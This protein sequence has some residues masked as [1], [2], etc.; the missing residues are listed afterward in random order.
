MRHDFITGAFVDGPAFSK[1]TKV[2]FMI[3]RQVVGGQYNGNN[4]L[5]LRVINDNDVQRAWGS[6]Y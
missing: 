5:L 6:T 1:I 3:D 2:P 4:N